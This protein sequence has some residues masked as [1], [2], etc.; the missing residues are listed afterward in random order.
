MRF[1]A[2]PFVRLFE[3]DRHPKI[4]GHKRTDQ[5]EASILPILSTSEANIGPILRISEANIDRQAGRWRDS[6]KK[7]H[8]AQTFRY[9]N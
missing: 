4:S 8:V 6:V 7:G 1:D 5:S 9:S 3:P 2:C